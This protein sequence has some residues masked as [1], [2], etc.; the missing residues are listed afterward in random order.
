MKIKEQYYMCVNCGGDFPRDEMCFDT[1]YD[2]DF[3]DDCMP[4]DEEEKWKKLLVME[5]FITIYLV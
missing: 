5:I 3:C 4:K 2:C 1:E